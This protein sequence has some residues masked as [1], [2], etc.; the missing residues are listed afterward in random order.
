MSFTVAID[1]G[2]T[3][4]DCVAVHSSG[5]FD[6]AKTFSTPPDFSVGIMTGLGLLAASAGC[7]LTELLRTTSLF[8][9]STTVAENAIVDGSMATAGLITTRGFEDTLYATRGGYGRWSGATETEKRDPI[10]TEKPPVLIPRNLIRGVEERTGP[11]GVRSVPA[12]DAELRSAVE[13]LLAAGVDAIGICL[14][15][16]FVDPE[17][18]E[19]IA[20]I[21]E[22]LGPSTFV[23][24][25][26]RIA[27]SLG[28]YERTSTTALNARLGPVVRDYLRGLEAGLAENGFAGRLLVM[29][30]YGG[31][32]P[33]AEA[34]DRPIG[35]IESGPVGGLLGS[36]D[37]AASMGITDVIAADM[38]GTTF[39]VGVVRDG[40]IEYER[41]S[42]ALRYH[43][44]AAKLD[45]ASLGLAGGS[46]I[47]V[48]PATGAPSIGPRS[49]GSFPGPVC[50][51]HGG[52]EP[53]ITDVDAILGYL[54]PDRFLG[55]AATLDVDAARDAFGDRVAGPLG[56]SVDDCAA[57]IYRLANS[58][59]FD[60]LHKATVQRGLDPRRFALVSIG[61]T[62][63]MHVASY[64][65]RLGVERV[66]IPSTASVHSAAGLI[67]SD[68]VHEEQI[69]RPARM[70]VPPEEIAATFEDL[71]RRVR[72]QLRRDGFADDDVRMLRSIDMRYAQQSHV[73]TV[74]AEG[75]DPF[76]APL[77]AKTI[78]RFEE[79]YRERYGPGSG[80]REAGIELVAYRLRGVGPVERAPLGEDPIE[81]ADPSD[82]L[83]ERRRAWVDDAGEFRD[84]AGYDFERLRPGHV[85]RGPAIVWTPITTIVLREADVARL[86]GRSNL[87][88]TPS[89]Q[90]PNER[91]E[92]RT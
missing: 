46:I 16:A 45:I 26:H 56:M 80:Y 59:F 67:Y 52:A 87:I 54:H 5:R 36:K 58:L 47:S 29:Q 86:D 2:G 44:A 92:V 57:S 64:A 7:T 89:S 77:L 88:L 61:G 18:E 23:T 66:I 6:M 82:A 90:R 12:D 43:F 22:V 41:E 73:V 72:A 34:A 33:A 25:S 8:L 84:V 39:K 51:G 74:P 49:A 20:R 40:A 38:G 9:H 3:C 83:I 27:P 85:I 24:A 13:D 50:Y 31:L 35:M 28:E 10:R 68:I 4:T 19:R 32:L 60:M 81:E 79:L 70:P 65:A 69:T 21:V 15:W 48:D 71:D 42:L 1:I 78:D 75:P 91:S 11:S 17:V 62:A 14:M 30:A 37:V 76:D 55:G 53:T 63:G